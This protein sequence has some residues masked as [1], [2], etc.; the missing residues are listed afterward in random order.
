MSIYSGK[1]AHVQVVVINCR[2][3]VAPMCTWEDT[4]PCL[5]YGP[6]F[7]CLSEKC[8]LYGLKCLLFKW[9]DLSH[10]QTIWKPDRKV[11]E[12]SNVQISC[13]RYS[14]CNCKPFWGIFRSVEGPSIT[15]STEDGDI[16]VWN[17]CQADVSK[18]CTRRGSI[19]VR[20]L[21]NQV[22]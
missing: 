11:S 10:D 15:V 13:N 3:S 17:D 21:H 6:F 14:D 18:F 4:L 22:Q 7:K 19:H 5:S 2:Y 1:L 8:L 16:H 12:K 9:S 20:D